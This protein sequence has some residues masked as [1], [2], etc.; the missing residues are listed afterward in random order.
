[1]TVS[2]HLSQKWSLKKHI[3]TNHQ[4]TKTGGKAINSD[5]FTQY[6]DLKIEYKSEKPERLEFY[7]Y[8][9]KEGQAN[10]KILTT[11]TKDLTHC[12]DSNKPLE[13][14]FDEWMKIL[15]DFCQKAFKKI[16][17]KRKKKTQHVKDSIR[18]LI[19]ERNKLISE[20]GNEAKVRE[21][22]EIIA[23]KEAEENREILMKNFKPLA[24]NPESINL[25][26]MWK[27][28]SKLWPKNSI[29]LP[30][31]KRNFKGKLLSS[32][33][34]IKNLLSLEYKN[35]LRSRPLRPDLKCI[36]KNK[37][38]IFKMKM[39]LAN[40]RKSELWK[41]EDLNK[42]LNNLK[43]KKARDSE[44]FLNEIF[45]LEVIGDD[46]KTSLL[47]LF[48]K[49]KS[50]KMIPRIFNVTNITTIPKSGSRTDPRNERGI[51]RVSV[52]RYILMR[53]IYDMKYRKIDEKM[54]DC[55][56]GARK[57]KGC[58]NNIFLIND[59]I[60]EA[61]NSK[62]RKPVVLQIYDYQQMFDSID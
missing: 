34:D 20:D 51:F 49:L 30:V 40:S 62:Q 19:D 9:N 18:I 44:G 52:L 16:R 15:R 59:I 46:L 58:K 2:C 42:A 12:F 43:N 57:N 29:C 54:S 32:P 47:I 25:K 22:E 35:R 36:T 24:D 31:A 1:M 13:K 56:M 8:K 48:N 21:I 14:Q 53:L 55:Q 50:E 23:E 26:E 3:L 4:A 60:H 28:H 7:D 37:K 38:R 45:K 10:F 17:I 5:H 33:R 39:A 61:M 11:E 27:L 6:M 41:M